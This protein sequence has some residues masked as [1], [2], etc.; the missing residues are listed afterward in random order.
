MKMR[1]TM[2]H[3]GLIYEMYFAKSSDERWLGKMHL[4]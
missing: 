1:S 2:T 3:I 4:I